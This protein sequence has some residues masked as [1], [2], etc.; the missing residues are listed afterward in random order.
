MRVPR[1]RLAN[2]LVAIAVGGV[3]LAGL[4]THGAVGAVLLIAVAAFLGYVSSQTWSALHPRGRSARLAVLA[5]VVA[6]AVV[7]IATR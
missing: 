1:S 7:K 2:L 5:A 3:F 4:F 6:V